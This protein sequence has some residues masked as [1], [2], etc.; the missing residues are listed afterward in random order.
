[1]SLS[2]LFVSVLASVLLL[3][4]THYNISPSGIQSSR[5]CYCPNGCVDWILISAARITSWYWWLWSSW[6]LC[7]LLPVD[8]NAN[9]CRKPLLGKQKFVR[10]YYGIFMLTLCSRSLC[11]K[12][13]SW[14]GN[15]KMTPKQIFSPDQVNGNPTGFCHRSAESHAL[16]FRY[17]DVIYPIYTFF[18]RSR[19]F[20]SG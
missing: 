1:M 19:D 14:G 10:G 17:P 13:S 2:V 12:F 4:S 11:Q 8:G 3:L 15:Q 6:M 18:R 16:F 9:L 20:D 5:L 7:L